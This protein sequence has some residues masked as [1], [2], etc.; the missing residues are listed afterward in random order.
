MRKLVIFII[1]MP[2]LF[3]CGRFVKQIFD[4]N[5]M[6][7]EYKYENDDMQIPMLQAF[8]MMKENWEYDMIQFTCTN[9]ETESIMITVDNGFTNITQSISNDQS[10]SE[11]NYNSLK[12]SITNFKSDIRIKKS[13][14]IIYFL[15]MEY[16]EIF[17]EE[18]FVQSSIFDIEE[19][20]K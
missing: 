1:F 10:K 13:K 16:P 5:I 2:L 8:L 7:L 18:K 11:N 14:E 3:G 4:N 17:I 20:E 19:K 12:I 15:I 9:N 6:M